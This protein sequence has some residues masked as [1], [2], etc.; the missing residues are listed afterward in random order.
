M[1]YERQILES[2]PRALTFEVDA[3][4]AAISALDDCSQACAAD[5]DADLG[6][7]DGNLDKMVKCIR[8]CLD[9][10][11]V[12]TAGMGILSRQ[13]DAD[14][15]VTRPLLQ[16]CVASCKSCGDECEHHAAMYVHCRVCAEACRRCETA[17]RELLQTIMKK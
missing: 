11:D 7:G 8:L 5:A 1:S 12:C 4:T 17:C 16:A 3:L 9:C 10:V 15:N 13:T 14:L 6:V 2:Y